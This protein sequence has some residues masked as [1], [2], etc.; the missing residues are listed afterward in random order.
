MKVTTDA[1][2]FGAWTA[3]LIQNSKL[4]I[5]NILDVGTGT[6]LLSLML[7][8]KNNAAIDAVE[9]DEQAYQQAKENFNDSPWK[10]RLFIHHNDI[11]QFDNKKKSDFIISNPPFFANDLRSDDQKKNAAKHDTTLTL[12]AL[13]TSAGKL[14]SPDGCM[15]TLLPYQRSKMFIDLLNRHDYFIWQNCAVRQTPT[16]EYFRSMLLFSKIKTEPVNTELI[17]KNQDGNYTEDFVELL[18]DYYLYL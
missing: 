12:E 15:A 3:Q 9:I 2:F 5:K 18:N 16:H 1:C 8:Q 10:E 14:L 6:G 13:L 7:A 11:L 4:K 17:I